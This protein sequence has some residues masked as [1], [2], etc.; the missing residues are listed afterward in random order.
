[1]RRQLIMTV[2]I[3]AGA[4]TLSAC[5]VFGSSGGPASP[6]VV[7]RP[8]TSSVSTPPSSA[9]SSPSSGAPGSTSSVPSSS[10]TTTSFAPIV[11]QVFAAL[12]GQTAVPIQGPA[13]PPGCAGGLNG[14][15][16]TCWTAAWYQVSATTYWAHV[17]LCPQRKAADLPLQRV[18]QA[19]CDQSMAALVAGYNFSGQRYPTAGDARAAVTPAPP[20]GSFTPV[21]LGNGVQGSASSAGIVVWTEGEWHL[22]VNFSLCPASSQPRQQALQT[23][24]SVVAFLHTHLL[25]ETFGEFQSGGSCGDTSSGGTSLSWAWGRDVY[26]VSSSGYA[27]LDAIRLAMAMRPAS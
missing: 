27:P 16:S 26:T 14:A 15:D 12:S 11:Q 17:G 8:A 21:A 2:A 3:L 25:P 10:A 19:T 9:P 4:A 18:G 7:S 13:N 24:Q 23:A 20:A 6:P 22:E 1:M 5:G